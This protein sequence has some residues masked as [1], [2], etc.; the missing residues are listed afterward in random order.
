MRASQ[1]NQRSITDCASSMPCFA[2]AENNC[3][4]T[5]VSRQASLVSCNTRMRIAAVQLVR[6]R[7]QYVRLAVA[8]EHPFEHGGILSAET[9][10]AIDDKHQSAPAIRAR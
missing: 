5:A 8:R 10:A 7:Q 4:V 9:A 3:A 1:P 6:L 2:C